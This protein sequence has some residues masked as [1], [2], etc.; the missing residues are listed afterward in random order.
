MAPSGRGGGGAFGV[1]DHLGAQMFHSL[2]R[3]DHTAELLALLGIGDSLVDHRHAGAQRIG[4]QHDAAGIDHAIECTV[5][6]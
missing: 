5:T 1:G 3:T 6:G 4:G 2:E